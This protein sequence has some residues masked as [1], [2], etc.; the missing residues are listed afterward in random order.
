MTLDNIDV[1]CPYCGETFST[2]VDTSVEHQV[3]T[4]DCYVCCQPIVFNVTSE[5]SGVLEVHT[6]TEDEC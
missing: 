2:Q 5:A 1:A 6:T 4:E 3:Y